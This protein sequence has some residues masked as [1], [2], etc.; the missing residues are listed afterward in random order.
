VSTPIYC[1]I[2]DIRAT[3]DQETLLG[4]ADRDGDGTVDTSVVN[5]AIN[6]GEGRIDSK[7]AARYSVPLAVSHALTP[8]A[9]RQV[10]IDFA[11]YRLYSGVPQTRNYGEHVRL[12]WETDY[13]DS[14]KMLDSWAVGPAEIPSLTST[15]MKPV[16]STG[17]AGSDVENVFT[18]TRYAVDGDAID[19]GEI[20]S[21][22]VM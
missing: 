17:L 15:G 16:M 2:G 5:M 4:L 1:T 12:P 14:M 21:M 19:T 22:D 11:R 10:C 9:I 18:M 3:I 6:W 7:L 13:K 20:G 8:N